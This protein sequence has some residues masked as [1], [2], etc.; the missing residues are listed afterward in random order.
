MKRTNRQEVERSSRG[1][2]ICTYKSI[3]LMKESSSVRALL[4]W[5]YFIEDSVSTYL[6]VGFPGYMNFATHVVETKLRDEDESKV[7]GAF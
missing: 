4:R 2:S 6:S 3:R 7:I 5:Y 1:R